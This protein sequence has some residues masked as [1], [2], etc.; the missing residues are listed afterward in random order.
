MKILLRV[1]TVISI[2]MIFFNLSK[3]NL[4]DPL[5]EDS[6]IGLIGV[7]A[8]AS[9]TIILLTLIV[10]RKIYSKIKNS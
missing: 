10:S 4:D 5:K 1:L 2:G 9:S 8:S 7:L 3:L 6:L